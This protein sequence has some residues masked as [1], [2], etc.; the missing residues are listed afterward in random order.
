MAN[1]HHNRKKKKHFNP[2]HHD[3]V[4]TKSKK[5]ATPIMTFGGALFGLII[6]YLAARD[7]VY[8]IAGGAI[9]G[10]IIGYFSGKRLDKTVE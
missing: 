9:A 3:H 6:G 5:S 8:I 10:L 4:A 1:P 2:P 7:N